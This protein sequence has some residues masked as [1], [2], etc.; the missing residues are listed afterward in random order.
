MDEW[1]E[2]DGR[3]IPTHWGDSV[4]TI[5]PLPDEVATELKSQGAKRVEIELSDHPYNCALTKAPVIDQTFVYTGKRILAETGIEPGE[6]IFV[7]VRK[8]DA[9]MVEVPSDVQAA[10]LQHG[11]IETW[12]KITPGRKRGMLHQVTS[13]KRPDTRAK[14]IEKLIASLTET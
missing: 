11:V 4:F 5:L 12:D 13:A 10:I 8:A 14:R 9:D 3:I 1:I 6:E 2:F 7:R